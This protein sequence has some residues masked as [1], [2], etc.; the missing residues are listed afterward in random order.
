MLT[1]YTHSPHAD[2]ASRSKLLLDICGV[3]GLVAL[4]A[5]I[6]IPL[7]FSPVPITLQTFSVLLAAALVSRERAVAGIGLYVF[8]GLLGAPLFAV[9]SGAT[10][11]Y[12]VAFLLAPHVVAR[13]RTPLAGMAAASLLIYLL[14]AAWLCYWLQIPV[15]VAVSIGVLPFVPGDLLKLMA[16]AKCAERMRD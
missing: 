16:A 11:G 9:A 1:T 15:M 13:F 14:G 3:A 7:P 6:R 4:G 5:L 8:L 2:A 12:L 10:L